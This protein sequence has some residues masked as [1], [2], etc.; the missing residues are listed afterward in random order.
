MALTFTK[1]T[2]CD[3]NDGSNLDKDIELRTCQQEVG[4]DFFHSIARDIN[5]RICS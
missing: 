3:L 4:E 2:L 5:I 1:I